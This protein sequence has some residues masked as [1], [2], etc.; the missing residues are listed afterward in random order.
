MNAQNTQI[1]VQHAHLQE[2][3]A[4]VVEDHAR[5]AEQIINEQ[6]AERE[7]EGNTSAPRFVP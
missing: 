6:M 7:D 5:P 1:E 3:A 2:G 4:V